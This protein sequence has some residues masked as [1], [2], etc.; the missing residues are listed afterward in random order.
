MGG[1]G[2][3]LGQDG[4]V[5]FLNPAAMSRIADTRLAFSVKL[6]RWTRAYY[7][8]MSAPPP[9]WGD[10]LP[11][12][13]TTRNRLRGIP[14]TFCAFMTLSGLLPEQNEG[15]L[16][17]LR[18][19]S[20]RVK[21][22]ICGANTEWSGIDVPAVGAERSED[23]RTTALALNMSSEWRRFAVGPSLSY[24]LSDSL[25][26]GASMHGLWTNVSD[27]WSVNA[28]RL[29]DAGEE[30]ATLSR[31][32]RGRSIDG[33]TT[34]G[35][36][37]ANGQ[38]FLGL[39]VR[40]PALHFEGKA[41]VNRTD[42]NPDNSVAV[43]LA[44][45]PFAAKPAT[46][47]R[48]GT[49]RETEKSRLEF[50][51]AYHF[52]SR[53]AVTSRLNETSYG[54]DGISSRRVN[55]VLRTRDTVTFEA[56]G[57]YLL[58]SRVSLLGGVQVAPSMLKQLPERDPLLVSTRTHRIAWSLG[59]GSYGSASELLTGVRVAYEW[60][61]LA[62]PRFKGN[63]LAV[64]DRRAWETLLILSGAVSLTSFRKTVERLSDLPT[65]IEVY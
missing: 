62:A 43:V 30:L 2:V 56:G 11:R 5:P 54:S 45:G 24:Q 46:V 29:N 1:T 39:S 9:T 55:Q 35:V 48:L 20:G 3:A 42:H 17:V 52:G 60:G 13:T 47:I 8:N 21:L 65:D 38:Q 25:T 31:A 34:Y 27:T 23:G 19:S 22:G 51:T 12:V 53:H 15:L 58:S 16:A 18:G 41:T 6:F 7:E 63:D 40:V 59:L 28:I 57:E 37:Y 64:A 33:Q 4:S 26:V 49:G 32:S 36:L 10:Q 14:S 50:D 44:E 61:T